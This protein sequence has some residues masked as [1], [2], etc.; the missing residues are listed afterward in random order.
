M[1]NKNLIFI[2]F[3]AA[4][5]ILPF[6]LFAEKYGTSKTEIREGDPRVT[7][8]SFNLQTEIAQGEM[9]STSIFFKTTK[10]IEMKEKVFFHLVKS[11]SQETSL[12]ADFSPRH[13]T[14]IWDV[15]Q[16]VEAGPI[17]LAIPFNLE[18]GVYDIQAGL[19]A[20]NR[21]ESEV[22][23]IR[24]PYTNQEIKDFT[25]GKL[26]V[27]KTEVEEKE[28]PSEFDLVSF[29]TD[30][31]M[32]FWET[33]GATIKLFK[34]SDDSGESINAAEVTILPGAGFPGIILDNYFS[35]QPSSSNWALYDT[36]KVNL[37]TPPTKAGSL[38]LKVS[39][40][41][42]RSYDSRITLEPGKT[43][44]ID[45]SMV[46]L[47]GLVDVS[48][49]A[50]V[51]L[52]L[53]SPK[54]AF[55][56]YISKLQLISRGMPTGKPAVTFVRLDGP[57]K[58]KRGQV[59]RVTPVFNINQPIFQKHKLFVQ[60]FRV[61]DHAGS[62]GTDVDLYPPVRNWELNKEIGVQSGPLEISEE[63]P[64]G[65]YVVRTGLYLVARTGGR[66]YVKMDDWNAYGGKE[67]INIMQPEGPIDYIKQPYTDL[68]IVDW[69]VG[70]IT[71]E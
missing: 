53:D 26:T 9:V 46:D 4:L 66:G 28:G 61:N 70:T 39:D 37:Y 38:R 68:D 19:M 34:Y 8:I 7:F 11:G 14:N 45:L 44:Q 71:V 49:I 56:F 63:S 2:L 47:S 31:D 10:P 58:I 3:V 6:A 33:L 27:T 32:I 30:Q 50:Q 35:I 52:F 65:T 54:K 16:V 12:N 40:K 43:K 24:E 13:P 51:K 42:G 69:E 18:P 1:K 5:L 41:T 25:I 48:N 20:I 22:Q 15:N 55:T 57:V 60:I 21:T 59:F 36:L 64:A 67:V 29:S 17:E 62:I 23:Y